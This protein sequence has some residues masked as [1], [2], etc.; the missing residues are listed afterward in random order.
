MIRGRE[1]GTQ[2][3]KMS[4][5]NSTVKRLLMGTL[6]KSR[7]RPGSRAYRLCGLYT[8]CTG[9]KEEGV[10][11]LNSKCPR[12]REVKI[13]RAVS[14]CKEHEGTHPPPKTKINTNDLLF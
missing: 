12:G 14:Q 5:P 7:R 6:L 8:Q 1:V 13:L 3:Q 4:M 9:C 2:V 10:I 11:S